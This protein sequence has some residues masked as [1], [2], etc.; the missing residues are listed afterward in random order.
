M[1]LRGGRHAEACSS[2]RM[3]RVEV[4]RRGDVGPRRG[5]SLNFGLGRPGVHL[6]Q[7]AASSILYHP[8]LIYELH[9][10]I[11]LA[12]KLSKRHCP[13][14]LFGRPRSFIFQSTIASLPDTAQV[15]FPCLEELW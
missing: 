11:L 4:V 13:T 10:D 3:G 7:I 2:A 12:M 14:C 1:M 8:V 9:I 15:T 6:Y 5:R